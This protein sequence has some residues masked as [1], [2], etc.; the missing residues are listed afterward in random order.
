MW[1]FPA[2]GVSS[3][4]KLDKVVTAR[5]ESSGLRLSLNPANCS[6]R[7]LSTGMETLERLMVDI[8]RATSRMN[9]GV[10]HLPKD[11]CVGIN[12]VR[13]GRILDQ[14]LLLE[15]TN[16]LLLCNI[17]RERAAGYVENKA[18]DREV[19]HLYRAGLQW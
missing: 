19:G 1:R 17:Y 3:E 16:R 7:P 4:Y 5:S 11:E 14:D 6:L 10:I 9:L 2:V 18:E 12:L 15:V 13:H 8:D